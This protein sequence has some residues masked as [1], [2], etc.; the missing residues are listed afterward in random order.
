MDK[1]LATIKFNIFTALGKFMYSTIIEIPFSDMAILQKSIEE[2]E[3]KLIAKH[4]RKRFSD[5]NVK[6]YIVEIH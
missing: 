5:V 3:E 2:Y 6:F 1:M 4:H